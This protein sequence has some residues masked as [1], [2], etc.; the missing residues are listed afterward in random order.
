MGREENINISQ[1]SEKN[2]DGSFVKSEQSLEKS[3][4]SEVNYKTELCRTWV[5]KNYCPYKEKCRFAHGKKDLHEKSVN[6]KHYKQKECNSFYKKGFC[7][8]GPRCHFKHEERKLEDI[9]RPYYEYLLKSSRNIE[10]I[11]RRNLNYSGNL[12]DEEELVSAQSSPYNSFMDDYSFGV[13]PNAG[14]HFNKLCGDVDFEHRELNDK[15]SLP[16][17][18]KIKNHNAP[19]PIA[20][21]KTSSKNAKQSRKFVL[22]KN[23]LN[24]FM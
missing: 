14:C 20:S 8:Y 4:S 21:S 7:P 18:Q 15:P 3:A 13:Y 22:H 19:S 17:F 9:S 24:S 5:E 6:S 16:V 10:K 2:G 11:L 1:I 12:S 23:I